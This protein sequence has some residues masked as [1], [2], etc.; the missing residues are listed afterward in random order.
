M[1]GDESLYLINRPICFCEREELITGVRCFQTTVLPNDNSPAEVPILASG[2]PPD[3]L[4]CDAFA[5]L[6]RT[7]P[8][9]SAGGHEKQCLGCSPLGG[10]EAPKFQLEDGSRACDN[11]ARP[12]PSARGPHFVHLPVLPV[13]RPLNGV[14]VQAFT[15]WGAPP[16]VVQALEVS[17]MCQLGAHVH[18]HL[19][20]AT[21]QVV[22]PR[23]QDDGC[24]ASSPGVAPAR[25]V[26]QAPDV[27]MW[28]NL[29]RLSRM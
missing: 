23:R 20:H 29:V 25:R 21:S 19:A 8:A 3:T 28:Y 11:C 24:G 13:P 27:C 6:E 17:G 14:A 12:P 16:L 7:G 22:W 2:E 5:L 10:G 26:V 9:I 15:Y 18:A 1:P 4:Q